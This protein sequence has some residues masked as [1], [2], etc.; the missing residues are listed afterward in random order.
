MTKRF[1]TGKGEVLLGFALA[2]PICLLLN[3]FFFANLAPR[4]KTVSV[5]AQPS[6]ATES[7][8]TSKQE[9]IDMIGYSADKA[10]GHHPALR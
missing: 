3:L 1:A 9:L 10:A 5:A 2:L 4:P 6:S 8:G 7:G